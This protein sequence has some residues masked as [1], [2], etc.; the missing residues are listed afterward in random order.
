M[1]EVVKISGRRTYGDAFIAA[2]QLWFAKPSGYVGVLFIAAVFAYPA[3]DD[4]PLWIV[5]LVGLVCAVTMMLFGFALQ[6]W[7]MVQWV[8]DVGVPA[9]TFDHSGGSCQSRGMVTH[10]PWSSIHQL[11]LT[12]RICFV[13]VTPRA[14]WF[15]RR[16]SLTPHE[17][18]ALFELARRANVRLRGAATSPLVG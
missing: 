2:M 4:F 11:R 9:Y 7:K 1:V 6:A 13:Y 8:S 5:A 3:R 18:S 14:A 17:E 10:V 12:K 16:D 15:F